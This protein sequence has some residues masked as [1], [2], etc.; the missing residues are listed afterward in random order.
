[1][2]QDGWHSSGGKARQQYHDPCPH[3]RYRW[4]FKNNHWCYQCTGALVSQPDGSK[5]PIGQWAFGPPQF[6]SSPFH[7]QPAGSPFTDPTP[8]QAA[9][10]AAT[11]PGKCRGKKGA[12]PPPRG[13]AKA[14]AAS[15]AGHVDRRPWVYHQ[16]WYP[17][18][19][20]S[21]P[22][23]PGN[24]MAALRA[25]LGD[26]GTEAPAA[27]EALLAKKEAPP[28]AA[29]RQPLLEDVSTKGV[30][31]RRAKSWLERCSLKVLE[32]EAWLQEARDTEDLA[33]TAAVEAK[34][35]WEEAC[36]KQ[37]PQPVSA[38]P[39]AAG[40]SSLNLSTLLGE[41][42][43][44]EGLTIVDGPMFSTEG[45]DLDPADLREWERVKSNLAAGIKAEISKALGSSVEQL[46]ALRAEAK[47]AE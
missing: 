9:A 7:V 39:A 35:S 6:S 22:P 12:P 5:R 26:D 19:G 1:M 20:A 40:A 10:A 3:C 33:A 47:Q 15:P 30:A 38:P 4:N 16:G 18:G 32:G 41:D 27:V 34:R 29:P 2:A 46:A 8:A 31:H 37:L 14:K 11:G 43:E 28:P 13:K 23:E 45:L 25:K 42:S 36:A 21:A 24:P 17:Y 44:V